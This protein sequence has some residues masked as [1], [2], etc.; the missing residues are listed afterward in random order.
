M[1]ERET[2][3]SKYLKNPK[4]GDLGEGVHV[5]RLIA[6]PVGKPTNHPDA[7]ELPRYDISVEFGVAVD[8]IDIVSSGSGSHFM[9]EEILGLG[10]NQAKGLREA[11]AQALIESFDMGEAFA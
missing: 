11:E 6:N 8:S 3:T 10:P 4:A 5:V 7:P 9:T 2:L 1:S